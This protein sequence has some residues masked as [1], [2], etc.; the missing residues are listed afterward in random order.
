M[1]TKPTS[2]TEEPFV[3]RPIRHDL[4]EFA[5]WSGHLPWTAYARLGF[6]VAALEE[7]GAE[8]NAWAQGNVPSD[9]SEAV[10]AALSAGRPPSEIRER[11]LV[12]RC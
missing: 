2:R 9:V 3:V 8:L 1:S 11:L 12:L 5:R 7:P 6:E 4:F 10:Q